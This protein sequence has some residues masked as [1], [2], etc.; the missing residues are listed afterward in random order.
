MSNAQVRIVTDGGVSLP[1]ETIQGLQIAIV[2]SLCKV[3]KQTL[4]SNAET[5]LLTIFRQAGG[6]DF[7]TASGLPLW[8]TAAWARLER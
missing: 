5:P 6:K 7:E 8:S 2:P 3:G 4:E 1:P